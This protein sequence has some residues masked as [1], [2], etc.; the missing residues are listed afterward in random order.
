METTRLPLRIRREGVLYKDQYQELYKAVAEFDGFCPAY[1]VSKRGPGGGFG[2]PRRSRPPRP[3]VPVDSEP[4]RSGNPLAARSKSETPDQSAVARDRRTGV[5]GLDPRLLLCYHPS[6]D[7]PPK[8]H[9]HLL[10]RAVRK[11]AVWTR[12][13]GSGFPLR[14]AFSASSLRN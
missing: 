2:R 10:L 12:T 9:A 5:K 1:H 6:L 3:A 14:R 11:S 4:R 7:I 13:A 8:L